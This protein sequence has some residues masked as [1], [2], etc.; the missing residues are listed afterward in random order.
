M[1]VTSPQPERIT[2][3]LTVQAP[4]GGRAHG[5]GLVIVSL[6]GTAISVDADPQQAFAQE[7]YTVAH[8]RLSPAYGDIRVRDEL[9]EATECLD[10]HDRCSNKSQYGIIGMRNLYII[11]LPILVAHSL[12]SLQFITLHLIHL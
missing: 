2:P 1:A 6:P 5:P 3:S 12:I 11:P 7:G 8:L 4:L 9:R 10:F